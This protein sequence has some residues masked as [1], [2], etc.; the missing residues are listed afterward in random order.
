MRSNLCSSV[1][2]CNCY[3]SITKPC[4]TLCDP[5]D[6]STPGFLVLHCLLE[7]AQTHVH[8][9]CDATQ[10]SCP[11][12]SPFLLAFSLA[13]HHQWPQSASISC[14]WQGLACSSHPLSLNGMLLGSKMANTIFLLGKLDWCLSWPWNTLEGRWGMRAG[15]RHPGP[16]SSGRA[17]ERGQG[18]S[19]QPCGSTG[20]APSVHVPTSRMRYPHL[21]T[22][23]W[24][25][26]QCL[27]WKGSV[28]CW[29]EHMELSDQ[30][31]PWQDR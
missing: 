3:C 14:C 20:R 15:G 24:L 2:P 7:L 17:R 26:G 1:I 5:M 23:G 22:W 10:P 16:G 29:W 27:L 9:V 8:Q 12:S 19:G 18:A 25:Q 21:P 13:Q 11:L 31:A 28:A 4:Q 6:C 30:S